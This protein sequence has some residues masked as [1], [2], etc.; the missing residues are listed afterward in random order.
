MFAFIKQ[1]KSD[2]KN[3]AQQNLYDIFS[4]LHGKD[5]KKP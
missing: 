5:S 1:N 4:N 3:F 2:A